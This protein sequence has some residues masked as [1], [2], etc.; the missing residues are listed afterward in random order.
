M[1]GPAWPWAGA[2]GVSLVMRCGG[3]VPLREIVLTR[4]PSQGIHGNCLFL[5]NCHLFSARTARRA[6]IPRGRRHASRPAADQGQLKGVGKGV[7]EVGKG[8]R[9]VPDTNGMVRQVLLVGAPEFIGHGLIEGG[10]ADPTG[11][12]FLHRG[13]KAYLPRRTLPF[14]RRPT[15]FPGLRS[16]PFQASRRTRRLR[17]GRTSFFDFSAVI[18]LVSR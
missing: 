17:R 3:H 12:Q 1:M 4:F 15:S 5:V 10:R 11:S 18:F 13:G 14:G 9:N 6:T 7:R 8:V 16:L 2:G